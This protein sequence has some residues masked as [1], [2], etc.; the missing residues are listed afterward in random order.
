MAWI[1]TVRLRRPDPLVIA[2][3]RSL[4]GRRPNFNPLLSV[5]DRFAGRLFFEK[6]GIIGIGG[7]AHLVAFDFGDQSSGQI[8]MVVGMR[9]ACRPW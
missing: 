6:G 2:D 4:G 1:S 8:V 7:Q 5:G 9:S 3:R